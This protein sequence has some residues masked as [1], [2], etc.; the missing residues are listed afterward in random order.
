MGREKGVAIS[1]NTMPLLA[2]PG[3][4]GIAGLSVGK[5]V[6]VL[7]GPMGV[8]KSTL[9]EYLAHAA[10]F[11][12]RDPEVGQATGS[13]CRRPQSNQRGVETGKRAKSSSGSANSPLFLPRIIIT[14]PERLHSYFHHDG[15][16]SHQCPLAIVVE[17]RGGVVDANKVTIIIRDVVSEAKRSGRI[18]FVIVDS[19]ANISGVSGDQRAPRYHAFNNIVNSIDYGYLIIVAQIRQGPDRFHPIVPSLAPS[20]HHRTHLVVQITLN[21]DVICLN[22]H[23][24]RVNLMP[25]SGCDVVLPERVVEFR[26]LGAMREEINSG[27]VPPLTGPAFNGRVLPLVAGQVEISLVS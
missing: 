6:I 9:C 23:R 17:S 18:P 24:A 5:M 21:R 3:M 12:T 13:T 16:G 19:I 15:N 11:S 8:G 4:F 1:R 25:V 2:P 22:S 14:E 10:E 26:P 20:N 27:R 7:Y